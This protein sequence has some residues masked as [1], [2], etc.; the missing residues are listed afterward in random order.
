M[1]RKLK[2]PRW[3]V[4]KS[5]LYQVY[6]DRPPHSLYAVQLPRPPREGGRHDLATDCKGYA[7]ELGVASGYYSESLLQNGQLTRLYSVDLWGDD[8]HNNHEYVSCVSRLAPYG[9]KSVVLRMDFSQALLHFPVHFF[10]FIYIDAFAHTG[11]QGGQLLIDWWSKLKPGGIFAGHD[12]SSSWPLTKAAVDRF[13]A[14]HELSIQT[15]PTTQT[16]CPEDRFE[17]WRIQKPHA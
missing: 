1:R 12:Y 2:L 4:I 10:D 5:A 8:N 7:L 3:S 17:S 6:H 13:A 15:Y 11:Q 16:G 14:Q 9:D